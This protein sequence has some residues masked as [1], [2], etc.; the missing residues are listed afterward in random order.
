MY[1]MAFF[2]GKK[3]VLTL[4][5]VESQLFGAILGLR[6]LLFVGT[7]SF[8]PQGRLFRVHEMGK[9]S[10]RIAVELQAMVQDYQI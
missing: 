2:G 7:S 9:L 5:S 1:S 3:K 10:W 6:L 8:I 4:L